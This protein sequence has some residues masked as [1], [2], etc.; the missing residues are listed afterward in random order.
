MDNY[1]TVSDDTKAVLDQNTGELTE[2]KKHIKLNQEDFIM[3][4]LNAI[5]EIANQL[6][7]NEMRLLMYTWKLSNYNANVTD[8]GN[9]ICNNTYTKKKIREFG[10]NMS[11]NAINVYFNRLAGKG[12]LIKVSTGMYMLNPKYFFKG[13]LSSRSHLQFILETKNQ[14][15][16]KS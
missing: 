1:I 5:P 8:E 6:E 12:F 16:G 11:D 7:R 10:C 3:V 13:S 14:K 15:D 2:Y 4:F 9:V